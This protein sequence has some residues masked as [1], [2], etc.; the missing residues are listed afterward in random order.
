[1]SD[2]IVGAIIVA[3]IRLATI[4]LEIFLCIFLPSLKV[5]NIMNNECVSITP[6]QE[7]PKITS[8][9]ILIKYQENKDLVERKNRSMRS[10]SFT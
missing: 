5:K 10:F 9:S 6:N 1:M 2:S 4:A 7:N 8:K 3:A